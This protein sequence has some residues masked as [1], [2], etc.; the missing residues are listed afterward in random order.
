MVQQYAADQT[1]PDAYRKKYRDTHSQINTQITSSVSETRAVVAN[2][3]RDDAIIKRT[4]IDRH[5]PIALDTLFS[6]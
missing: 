6:K 2:T 1:P 5:G 3:L 4:T